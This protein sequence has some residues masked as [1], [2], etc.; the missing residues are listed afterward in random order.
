MGQSAHP[1]FIGGTRRTSK[2]QGKAGAPRFRQQSVF[3]L[4]A[5]TPRAASLPNDFLRDGYFL[6][7]K[8]SEAEFM[9]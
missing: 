5:E 8:S 9:Q 1:F 3:P 6:G 4:S 2:R 7:L